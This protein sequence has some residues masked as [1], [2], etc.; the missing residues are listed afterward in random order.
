MRFLM[1]PPRPIK[2]MGPRRRDPPIEVVHFADPWCWWSWGL[3]PIL[4]RLREVYGDNVQITYKMGGEFESLKAWM[5]EYGLDET[6]T[7]DWILES[8]ALTHMPVQPDYY[9]R[10]HVESSFPA[11]KAFKAA[12]LQSEDKAAKYFRRM[13]EAFGLECLPAT[14]DTLVKLG[15]DVGLDKDGLRKDMHSDAVEEAFERDRQEMMRDRANFDA[16]LVRDREGHMEM[17]GATFSAKPFEEIIDRLAPGLP[18]R[19]PADILEYLEHHKDLTPAHEIAS[20][21]RIPGADAEMRLSK[22]E[23]G[24]LLTRHRFDG[25]ETWQWKGT[26]VEK[27]PLGIVKVSHVPPEVQVEAVSDLKPII[28][29]AVQSLYTEVP[30]RPDKAYHFPLALEALRYLGYP[31]Q[32]LQKLP[33]TATEAFAGVGYPHAANAIRP[34]DTVLDIGSGS[35]TDVLYA[36]LKTGRSG[37]VYGLDITPAMITKARA[38]IKRIGAKNVQILEGDATRIPLP[39][40]SADVVTSNGVLNLVPDKPAAFREIFRVLKPGGRLQLADIVVQVDV[41][42]V[43]GLNPQLWADCIGGAAVEPEYMETIRAAG[44]QDVRVLKRIDYFAKSSS[45]STKRLTKT[46]GAESVV[47]AARKP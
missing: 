2:T 25:I 6:S 8:V 43:C 7:V 39:D 11:C 24:G 40:A 14:D 22:L 3:E 12:T 47:V 34:G 23:R 45:E 28:T 38:N 9:F 46:F 36:S 20:V 30:T 41:G 1:P 18:K 16:F 29:K 37:K 21:F 31:D 19:N 32:H 27:L 26:R 17:K 42:A 44:F 13:M 15:G 5:Q 33:S 4:Q 35:G 10:C